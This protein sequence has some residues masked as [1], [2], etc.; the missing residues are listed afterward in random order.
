MHYQEWISK[1]ISDAQENGCLDRLVTVSDHT[2]EYFY[3]L[4]CDPTVHAILNE[5]EYAVAA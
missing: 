1:L 4:G 3:K 5:S 2:L